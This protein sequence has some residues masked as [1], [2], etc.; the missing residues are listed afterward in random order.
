[1]DKHFITVS[2]LQLHFVVLLFF[3][4]QITFVV[5][6]KR[7]PAFSGVDIVTESN[8]YEDNY[9]FKRL[10]VVVIVNCKMIGGG[11]GIF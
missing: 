7:H 10:H 11:G 1:M 6:P 4:S 2:S 5:M 8:S 3:V 9:Y